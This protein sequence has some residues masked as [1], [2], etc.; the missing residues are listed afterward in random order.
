MGRKSNAKERLINSAIELIGTRSY[1]S[2]GV[3][4]ICEHAGVKKGSFYHFFPSKSDL[5]VAALDA[6]WKYFQEHVLMIPISC[7]S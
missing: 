5:T 2:V 4:E 7:I 1:N 6:M 3:Q